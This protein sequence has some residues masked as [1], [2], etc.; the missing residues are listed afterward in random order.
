MSLFEWLIRGESR[1]RRRKG[2]LN[3]PIWLD[4][5]VDKQGSYMPILNPL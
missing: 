3:R 4:S 1:L 5:H 2:D